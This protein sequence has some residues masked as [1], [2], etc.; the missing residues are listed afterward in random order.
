LIQHLSQQIIDSAPLKSLWNTQ[1]KNAASRTS[2]F[3][4][5]ADIP[6]ETTNV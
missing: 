2:E 3:E 5:S 4:W 1:C 6:K